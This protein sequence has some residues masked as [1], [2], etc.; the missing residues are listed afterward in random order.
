MRSTIFPA[1]LLLA[2][3]TTV[4]CGPN[5]PARNSLQA[6]VVAALDSLVA[7]LVA[8]RPA[9]ADAY[10]ERLRV[11]LE[12]HPAFYGA[13]A[14]LLDEAGAVTASPYVYRAADG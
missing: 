5:E 1:L 12:A 4:A 7:E 14:A 9:D 10:A 6:T 3:V 11:Y 2:L 13:A 8:E